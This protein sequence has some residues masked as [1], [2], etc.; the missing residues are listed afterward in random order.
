MTNVANFSGSSRRTEIFTAVGIGLLIL[1]MLVMVLH[2]P[3]ARQTDPAAFIDSI[4]RQASANRLVHGILAAAMTLMTSL[5]LGFAARLGLMRPHILLGAVS[6]ALALVLICLAVTLDGFVVPTLAMRCVSIGG[7]CAR[8]TQTLLRF[9]GLQIEYMTRLGF[10]ALAGATALWAG[11][12][13]LGKKGARTVGVLGLISSAGQIG[14][15]VLGG[16]RLNPH[17]LGLIVAAQAVW[18]LSIGAMIVLRQ[19]P[20]TVNPRD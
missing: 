8:E 7:D 17:S 18:Y 20:Y 11:D 13:V 9:G 2:H 6:S 19:G 14:I 10:F 3:T 12:L 15:L 1:L 5:M 4:A 16:E